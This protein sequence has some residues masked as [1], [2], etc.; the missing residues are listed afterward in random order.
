MPNTGPQ[1][2][3]PVATLMQGRGPQA[4]MVQNPSAS[5]LKVALL[6]AAQNPDLYLTDE[7]RRMVS[8]QVQ[9]ATA[10]NPQTGFGVDPA[11]GVP[12]RQGAGGERIPFNPAW[13][14][15]GGKAATD[16]GRLTGEQ[17]PATQPPDGFVWA[18]GATGWEQVKAPAPKYA[19]KFTDPDTPPPKDKWPE[20]FEAAWDDEHG[21]WT[22]KATPKPQMTGIDPK[23]GQFI[24]GSSGGAPSGVAP[25]G[26]AA[27]GDDPFGIFT[28]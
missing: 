16:T 11:T 9:K 8:E 5:P 22:W 1:A 17:P 24:Y 23:T 3:D 14:L 25:G 20:G 6:K 7:G 26:A 27:N 2:D 13:L 21:H 12:Y 28:K 19:G 18:R 15:P 4:N 10:Q